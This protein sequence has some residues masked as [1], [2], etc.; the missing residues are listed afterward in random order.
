MT[1]PLQIK[2]TLG[3]ILIDCKQLHSSFHI[4]LRLTTP[5]KMLRLL[6]ISLLSA[7]TFGT[8]TTVPFGETKSA[9]TLFQP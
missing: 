2:Y 9:E 6:F 1:I 3:N 4:E 8:K 7:V 5:N